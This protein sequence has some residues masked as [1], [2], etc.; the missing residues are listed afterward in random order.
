[1]IQI[2]NICFVLILCNIDLFYLQPLNYVLMKLVLHRKTYDYQVSY[3]QVL[4]ILGCGVFSYNLPSGFHLIILE[5]QGGQNKRT[6][7]F[8]VIESSDYVFCFILF[9]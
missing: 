2:S 4:R 9:L 8:F 5:G 1:M 3:H 7:N 6:P